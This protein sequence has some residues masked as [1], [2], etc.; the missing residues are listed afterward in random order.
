V[1]LNEDG[2][3]LI[4]IIEGKSKAARRML[5]MTSRVHSLLTARWQAARKP[6]DGWIFPST[7]ECGHLNADTTKD[8]HKK[9]LENSAL[10]PFVPYVLRHT[11]LTRLGEAASGDIFVLARIAGHSSITITQRYVHPQAD[12]I[13]RVFAASQYPLG[14]KMGTAK[15]SAKGTGRVSNQQGTRKQLIPVKKDGAGRG[16]RTPTG[17]LSPADFK[18]AASANFAIPARVSF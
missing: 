7:S 5:P 3:G 11:A 13:G 1:L 15:K 12:A 18:S 17:L 2:T 14:T 9:A 10:E 4:Q 16:N 8:Q 6:T